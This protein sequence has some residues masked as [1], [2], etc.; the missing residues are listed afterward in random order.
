VPTNAVRH[1]LLRRYA[2][3][4]IAITATATLCLTLGRGVAQS[5]EK[6]ENTQAIEAAAKRAHFWRVIAGKEAPGAPTVE[7]RLAK[8]LKS[9]LGPVTADASELPN[10]IHRFRGSSNAYGGISDAIGMDPFDESGL[11]CN[12][13]GPLDANTKAKLLLIKQGQVDQVIVSDQP[14]TIPAGYTLTPFGWSGLTTGLLLW[15]LGGP[16]VLLGAHRWASASTNNGYNL[17][18]FGDLSWKLDGEA[19][20]AK[21]TSMA[22]APTFFA[23]YLPYRAANYRRFCQQVREKFPNQMGE[24]DE[25]DRFLRRMP[26][27]YT[28]DRRVKELQ[29]QRNDLMAELESLTRSGVS[30][31]FDF[32]IAMRSE[33]LAGTKQHLQ[34]R[35]RAQATLENQPQDNHRQLER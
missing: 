10:S 22:L 6:H 14:E 7:N 34:D 11:A 21:L 15:A 33:E 5:I 28:D 17:R 16:L 20:G 26:D 9:R 25:I 19:D 1:R 31:G 32:E 2:A 23:F 24:I 30:S 27:R 8:D 13:C 12:E 29:R 18:R 35:L 4:I 3:K